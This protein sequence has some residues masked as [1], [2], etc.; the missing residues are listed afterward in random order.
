M[1]ADHKAIDILCERLREKEHNPIPPTTF[2]Y[3][4]KACRRQKEPRAI[5]KEYT[6]NTTGLIHMLEENLFNTKDYNLRRRMR[7]I[8]EGLKQ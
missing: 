4:L 1:L 2:T 6:N 7:R 5:A 3:F 8:I